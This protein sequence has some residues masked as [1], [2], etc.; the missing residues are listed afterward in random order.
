M[1]ACPASVLVGMGLGIDRTHLHDAFFFLLVVMGG[2]RELGWRGS[3]QGGP[4]FCGGVFQDRGLIFFFF[5]LG[6]N[7]R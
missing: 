4:S 5:F 2:R 1:A 6:V 7:V 3:W